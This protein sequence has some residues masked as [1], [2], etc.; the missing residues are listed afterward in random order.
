MRLAVSAALWTA[1]GSGQMGNAG[2]GQVK[3]ISVKPDKKERVSNSITRLEVHS[4][5]KTNNNAEETPRCIND[6]VKGLNVPQISSILDRPE[7]DSRLH[8]AEEK[9][10]TLTKELTEMEMCKIELSD[11]VI[12]LEEQLEIMGNKLSSA[13]LYEETLIAKDKKQKHKRIVRKLQI[14]LAQVKQDSAISVTKAKERIQALE[15]EIKLTKEQIFSNKHLKEDLRSRASDV[16]KL[17]L[18]EESRM[19]LVLELSMQLSQQQ[20]KILLLEKT[21]EE[22]DRQLT[23]LAAQQFTQP[24]AGGLVH[25][26][27]QPDLPT[28]LQNNPCTTKC[29]QRLG[30]VPV[31]ASDLTSNR[32]QN[33]QVNQS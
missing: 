28:L 7:T 3:V 8:E 21:L 11:Q 24:A 15:S 27:L 1:T 29:D 4:L 2:S 26:L 5:A 10:R 32:S 6:M 25:L 12:W 31:L 22:K 33:S 17:S 18:G 14:K 13:G 20:E 19:R 23:G 16:H 9:A 30:A